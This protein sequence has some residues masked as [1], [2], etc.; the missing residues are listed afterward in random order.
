[1]DQKL[2]TYV[3]ERGGGE[4]EGEREG[5]TRNETSLVN[6]KHKLRNSM[7][8][9]EKFSD[10]FLQVFSKFEIIQNQKLKPS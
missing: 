10:P 2:H 3:Y 9:I 6:M 8:G 1:M 5:R 4:G 7:K